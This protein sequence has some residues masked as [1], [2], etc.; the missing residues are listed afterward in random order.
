[1]AEWGTI[2]FS[3]LTS[4]QDFQA[5]NDEQ[6]ARV[7]N[8]WA[9]KKIAQ[10]QDGPNL[11][12]RVA[13]IDRAVTSGMRADFVDAM[14]Q[15]LVAGRAPND[16]GSDFRT[17]VRG[18][19]GGF[20]ENVDRSAGRAL[21][22]VAQQ[23]AALPMIFGVAEAKELEDRA[24]EF[25]AAQRVANQPLLNEAQRR[26]LE[27]WNVLED[28]LNPD[29]WA[30]EQAESILT[31]AP[32]IA[33]GVAAAPLT[34]GSTLGVA[35]VGAGLGAAGGLQV[36]AETYNELRS[37]GRTRE[38]AGEAARRVAVTAGAAGTAFGAATGGLLAVA[39]KTLS[40]VL[41]RGIAEMGRR[42]AALNA[43]KAAGTVGVSA[44]LEGSQE[45]YETAIQQA[46]EEWAR[47]KFDL[48]KEPSDWIF[49]AISEISPV[50]I[51]GDADKMKTFVAGATTGL[52]ID[53]GP[54]TAAAV[55]E[56]VTQYEN[57]AIGDAEVVKRLTELRDEVTKAKG[58]EL[59]A[60]ASRQG[61]VQPVSQDEAGLRQ[62]VLQKAGAKLTEAQ[63]TR[64]L[65]LVPVEEGTG[66]A[67]AVEQLQQRTNEQ[68]AQFEAPEL[69]VE[70]VQPD[71]GTQE[72]IDIVQ[73]ITGK[74]VV[75]VRGVDAEGNVNPLTEQGVADIDNNVIIV[76]STGVQNTIQETLSHEMVHVIQQQAPE[77]FDQIAQAATQDQEAVTRWLANTNR[78]REAQGLPQLNAPEA[79]AQEEFVADFVGQLA[80]DPAFLQNIA[81][82]NPAAFDDAA[83]IADGFFERA[84]NILR[85]E[86]PRKI[87]AQVTEARSAIEGILA[88]FAN[89]P[90]APTAQAP[91]QLPTLQTEG[92]TPSIP[93]SERVRQIVRARRE[94]PV[95]E[96]AALRRQVETELEQIDREIEART[97]ERQRLRQELDV[98]I[99]QRTIAEEQAQSPDLAAFAAPF[100]FGETTLSEQE[101]VALRSALGLL[102]LDERFDESSDRYNSYA[103]FSNEILLNATMTMISGQPRASRKNLA[104]PFKSAKYREWDLAHI[105]PASEAA[106][107]PTVRTRADVRADADKAQEG[108]G[109]GSL[110]ALV[111][112]AERGQLPLED[113]EVKTELFRRALEH[114]ETLGSLNS[115]AHRKRV[116]NLLLQY[117]DFGTEVSR[118]L[119]ARRDLFESPAE[120]AAHYGKKMVSTPDATLTGQWDAAVA[121]GD[122]QAA[123]KILSKIAD[124]Q[125]IILS[126][127]ELDGIDLDTIDWTNPDEVANVARIVNGANWTPDPTQRNNMINE[128]F[129]SVILGS[130][131]TITTNVLGAGYGIMQLGLVNPTANIVAS[132]QDG[133]V[134]LN[135]EALNEAAMVARLTLSPRIVGEALKIG[136]RSYK[137]QSGAWQAQRAIDSG[138][139][140]D[141]ASVFDSRRGGQIRGFGRAVARKAGSI[142]DSS[143]VRKGT[144]RA[145]DAFARLVSVGPDAI[146]AID[147]MLRYLF[148]RAATSWAAIE[149][150]HQQGLE[151]QALEAHVLAELDNPL[152]QTSKA[153][154][155]IANALLFQDRQDL[156]ATPV[157][158]D[159]AS[160][161]M[162]VKARD[163]KVDGFVHG[164]VGAIA[165]QFFPFVGT[166]LNLLRVSAGKLT[167]YAALT[168][169]MK[170][171]NTFY[172]GR[173]NQ[174]GG[175]VYNNTAEVAQDVVN[176]SVVSLA[177]WAV[178]QAMF[179]GEDDEPFITGG[180]P[181]S[182]F[183]NEARFGRETAPPMSIKIAGK[184][185]SYSRVD[186]FASVL[187]AMVDTAEAMLRLDKDQDPKEV[188]ARLADRLAG[189]VNE[190]AMLR[191][192]SDINRL[193]QA[194]I[195]GEPGAIEQWATNLAVSYVPATVRHVSMDSDDFIREHSTFLETEA[196]RI[197]Q[198]TVRATEQTAMP[199]LDW[200]GRERTK[201]VEGPSTTLAARLVA[202]LYTIEIPE[203]EL[204]SVIM[205][206]NDENIG[207]TDYYPTFYKKSMRIDG[208]RV[209]LTEQE[210][211]DMLKMRGEG[212]QKKWRSNRKIW[213]VNVEEPTERDMERIKKMIDNEHRKAREK[214]KKRVEKR[215]KSE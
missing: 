77:V 207:D 13:E 7:A 156:E 67:A 183:T 133:G 164:G 62:E 192:V 69:T 102:Q 180:G 214:I 75:L 145:A 83:D 206:W 12:S 66:A 20:W 78:V 129:V 187:G 71:E 144:A 105:Q 122:Q 87:A 202:P 138:D 68:R 200:L 197:R 73:Q 89:R 22:N 178:I 213:K 141:A 94:A 132:A 155:E 81:N 80:L 99:E 51:L 193:V 186:P 100:D 65:A 23:A 72:A 140:G 82:N 162:K 54:A 64:D 116:A 39:G 112:A 107:A 95:A 21:G 212:I 91:R 3:E 27:D 97:D 93:G 147:E 101:K 146:V 125:E 109:D 1:V 74:D 126:E 84:L 92:G 167:P 86:P 159:L 90:E 130:A 108:I 19:A 17:A 169:M 96:T 104:V 209:E 196:S 198:R 160:A 191:Q 188:Y 63:A 179:Q 176:A 48:E 148:F 49:P 35:A 41:S 136:V 182:P 111:V 139:S 173:T 114:V 121:A 33:G 106:G 15:D 88:Q 170:G 134:T 153:G 189:Q 8:H 42:Q 208:E 70:A 175:W 47:Q 137:N 205:N 149:T 29:W 31:S 32:L 201:G 163:R 181:L 5:L 120:R 56:T 60:I 215:L 98:E 113:L 76:D 58:E 177:W 190:K 194:G 52:L 204:N 11:T 53:A 184:W 14:V 26:D 45:V 165:R 6:R 135:T 34:G 50:E 103:D 168:T 36:A 128:W 123:D 124:K 18:D 37:Q 119:A 46:G 79:L 142:T 166:P 158:G 157:L 85:G 172:R 43:G 38:E 9:T 150:G 127:F 61:I 44:A 154:A 161:I 143:K 2:S 211:F 117:R 25:A 185:R 110:D 195:S 203:A 40:P 10:A 210:W 24:R 4:R 55:R 174:H 118:A 59:Q 171:A 115:F 28:A 131:K 16:S 199:K 152:S 30:T 57:G 151:G